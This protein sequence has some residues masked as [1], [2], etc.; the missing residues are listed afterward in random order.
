MATMTMQREKRVWH[1][2]KGLLFVCRNVSMNGNVST[3]RIK[4][5][6]QFNL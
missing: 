5:R 1:Q 4:G 6:R 3:R 2:K